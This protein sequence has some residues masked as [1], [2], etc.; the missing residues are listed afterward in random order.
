MRLRLFCLYLIFAPLQAVGADAAL[1][2]LGE[3]RA[4]AENF[5][6][7]Q[8]ADLPGQ[9]TVG[10]GAVDSRLRLAACSE[11]E[12]FLPA[13]SRLWGAATVG[14]RCRKPAS[15]TVYV[16]V[17]I[18]VMA[19]VV[20]AAKSLPHGQVIGQADILTRTEDITQLPG[21]ILNDPLQAIGKTLAGSVPSGYPLR[22][23]ALR[24][25]LA[26]TQGQIVKVVAQGR[27]FRV[28]SEG[29]ALANATE[30]QTVTVRTS[31][32]QIVSGTARAGGIVEVPF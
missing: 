3:I 15:W 12:A 26:V 24:S 25:P 29:K 32:G 23:D 21:N 18:K 10:A 31:S 22:A 27:G 16:P 7:R 14:V 8:T 1:Q 20:V 30:G 5:A 4:I 9:V 11:P 2:D 19:S 17:S 28:S 13:G 6:L